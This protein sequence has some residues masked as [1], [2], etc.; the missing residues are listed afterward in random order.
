MSLLFELPLFWLLLFDEGLSCFCGAGEDGLVGFD[1]D[2]GAATS[3]GLF[4]EYAPAGPDG[5][6]GSG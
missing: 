5:C 1:V 3:T 6:L 2:E 4:S